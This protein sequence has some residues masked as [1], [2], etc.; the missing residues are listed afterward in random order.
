LKDPAARSRLE[1]ALG[2]V[3][4]SEEAERQVGELEEILREMTMW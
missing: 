2:A 4:G 3:V 1:E